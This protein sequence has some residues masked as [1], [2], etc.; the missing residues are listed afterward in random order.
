MNREQGYE[1]D[2]YVIQNMDRNC[3]SNR[4]ALYSYQSEEDYVW[5][6]LKECMQP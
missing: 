5:Q 3:C 4:I 6:Y 1:H 2:F